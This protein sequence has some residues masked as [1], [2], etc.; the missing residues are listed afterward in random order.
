[1]TEIADGLDSP[2][3]CL[4]HWTIIFSFLA[5]NIGQSVCEAGFM[6]DLFT[7]SWQRLAINF[8]ESVCPFWAS[9]YLQTKLGHFLCLVASMPQMKLSPS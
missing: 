2:Q 9:F 7:M 8:P 3:Y 1:M 4:K 5:Q 6:K